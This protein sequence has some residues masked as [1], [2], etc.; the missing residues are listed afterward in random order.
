MMQSMRVRMTISFILLL[1]I[2][3]WLISIAIAHTTQLMERY[4]LASQQ[5]HIRFALTTFMVLLFPLAAVGIWVLVSRTL[6]PLRALSRQAEES[7]SGRLEPP[8]SDVE[9]VELVTTLNHLLDRVEVSANAKAQFYA[10]ASHELRTP[11]QALNGHIETALSKKR[12]A[13]EY[14]LALTEAQKQTQRLTLLTRDILMLHQLQTQP[15]GGGERAD[16]AQS[17]TTIL[18]ELEPLIEARSL[19]V[20]GEIPDSFPMAGRQSYADVCVRNL[21][22]NAVRYSL[23]ASVVTI[24]FGTDRLEIRNPCDLDHA[25][26]WE[27]FFEPFAAKGMIV[28]GQGNGL[29]LAVCRAAAEANGW[30][31]HLARQGSEVVATVRF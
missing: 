7:A 4:D 26:D 31:V 6:S 16:L 9:M 11:L 13:E 3:G 21:V 20:S 15:P 28:G 17:M 29:G 23:P 19:S 18:R 30:S 5:H 8:S 25:V 14:R 12:P 27:S 1:A 22:E 24:R 2:F 10:A